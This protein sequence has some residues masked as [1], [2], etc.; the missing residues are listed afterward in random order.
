MVWANS[1]DRWAMPEI[2]LN[3][4]PVRSAEADPAST[5][6]VS[7]SMATQ[8]ATDAARLTVEDMAKLAD[9]LTASVAQ[10]KLA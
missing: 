3:T 2:S 4:S 6:W 9:G 7:C 1:A 10:F 5:A 8:K